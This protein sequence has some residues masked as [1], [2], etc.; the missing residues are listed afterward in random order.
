MRAL[1]PGRIEI[2]SVEGGKPENLEKTLGA[3]KRTNNKHNPHMMLGLGIEPGPHWW[4]ASALTT[5]PS[6]LPFV[7][8]DVL[9]VS[10]CVRYVQTE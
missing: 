1:Y 8:T 3:R 7:K 9:V 10:L 5:T 2:W 6:L 4:E